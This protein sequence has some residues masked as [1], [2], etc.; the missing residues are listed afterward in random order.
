MRLVLV[1]RMP[2]VWGISRGCDKE[3]CKWRWEQ[4]SY[5]GVSVRSLSVE[6]RKLT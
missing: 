5:E 2:V 3:S 4:S 6:N 1:Q